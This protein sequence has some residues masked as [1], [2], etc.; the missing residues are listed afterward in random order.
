LVLFPGTA[1]VSPP[2]SVTATANDVFVV[3]QSNKPSLQNPQYQAIYAVVHNDERVKMGDAPRDML[4]KQVQAAQSSPFKDP[5]SPTSFDIRFSHSII[6]LYFAAQNTATAGE[7][8]NYTSE[9]NYAGQDPLQHSQLLYENTLRYDMDSD[10]FAGVAPILF[11]DAAPH[12][13]GYHLISYSLNVWDNDPKGSTN[14]S[15]LANVSIVHTTSTA[16]QNAAGLNALGIPV[17]SAGNPIVFPNAS[18]VLVAQPQKWNHILH[19]CNHQIVRVAH[20]SIG[21]PVL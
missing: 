19:A 20:G 12:E 7:W 8:S 3:G 17:D 21:Q 1:A 11:S 9:P 13:T 6:A 15:K 14:Y 2:G 4:I 5:A 18:G 16:A 10:Y